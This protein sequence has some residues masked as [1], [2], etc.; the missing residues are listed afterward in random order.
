MQKD[1]NAHRCESDPDGG[2]RG[3]EETE[4]KKGTERRREARRRRHRCQGGGGGVHGMW[5]REH[6]CA[7]PPQ[8]QVQD[9]QT[10]VKPLQGLPI[11]VLFDTFSINYT[12]E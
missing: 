6:L 10:A 5:G 7:Y 3:R 12:R 8:E 9:M 1:A 2:R 4:E 11:W